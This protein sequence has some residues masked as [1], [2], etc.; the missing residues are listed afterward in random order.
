MS[1]DDFDREGRGDVGE[2]YNE[3]EDGEPETEDEDS[4]DE[5]DDSF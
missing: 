1:D 4:Y 2:I 3:G 5:E